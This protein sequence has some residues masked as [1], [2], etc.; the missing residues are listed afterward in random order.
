[1]NNYGSKKKAL[2]GVILVLIGI[3]LVV[4]KLG[5]IQNLSMFKL[6]CTG[7]LAYISIKHIWRLEFFGFFFPL[8]FIGILYAEELKIVPITPW[9][10]LFVAFLFSM[11]LS[12]IF[13]GKRRRINMKFSSDKI[14]DYEDESFI[15]LDVLFTESI[16]Y[17]S[18]K[19]FK[20][21]DLDC[22]FSGVKLYFEDVVF[23]GETAS[24]KIDANFSGVEI[25]LPKNWT[26]ENRLETMFGGVNERGSSDRESDIR[27]ILE[28][29]L[30]F[31]GLDIYY[32]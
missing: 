2:W 7:I 4:D 23:E 16:K 3:L 13:K 25:Y 31:S 6:G 12:L 5:Y 29:D 30:N 21:L 9:I 22:N 17:L 18:N 15:K 32:I 1:M 27:L 20:R 28:G 11:G 24:L 8:A 26:V 14:I 10:I 19:K